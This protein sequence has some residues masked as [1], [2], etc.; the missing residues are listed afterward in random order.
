MG[1]DTTIVADVVRRDIPLLISKPEMQ[2]R[3]FN[4][5]MEEDILQVKKI[6]KSLHL[7]STE[8]GHY[9]LPLLAVEEVNIADLPSQNTEKKRKSIEKL[10]KAFFHPG[11]KS[12]KDLFKNAGEFDKEMEKMVDEISKKCEFCLRYRKARPKPIVSMPMAKKFND[13]V[14]MDLKHHENI[15]FIHFIDL[16][17]RLL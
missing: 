3:G 13:I 5:L 2:K 1:E 12:L 9:K 15:Y 7:D 16:F 6:G 17:T 11:S 8:T 14:A 10:H 4:L